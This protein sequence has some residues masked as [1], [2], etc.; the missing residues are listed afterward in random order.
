M[1]DLE[2]S[3]RILAAQM[4]GLFWLFSVRVGVFYLRDVFKGKEGL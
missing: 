2:T 1:M 3:L 4:G